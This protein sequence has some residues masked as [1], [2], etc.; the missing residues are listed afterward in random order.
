MLAKNGAGATEPIPNSGPRFTGANQEEMKGTVISMN[1]KQDTSQQYEN[2]VKKLY[3]LAGK[4]NPMPF[5][6]NV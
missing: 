3:V 1:S 4:T 2:F 6:I 5:F